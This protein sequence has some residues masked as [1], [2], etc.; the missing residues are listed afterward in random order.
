M[1]VALELQLRAGELEA[2]SSVREAVGQMT[3]AD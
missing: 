2:F 1:H 3:I